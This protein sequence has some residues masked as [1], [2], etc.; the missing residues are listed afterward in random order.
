[1]NF[2]QRFLDNDSKFGQLMTRAGIIIAANLTFLAFCLPVVTIGP[3]WAALH[4]TMLKTLREK[5]L[6]PFSTFWQGFREN[7]FQGLAAELG[8]GMLTVFLL[9]ESFWCSQFT[10]PVAWFRYGVWMLLGC[11]AILGLYLFPVMAAF[12]GSLLQKLQASLVFAMGNIASLAGILLV[13]AAPLALT[14]LDAVRMPLYAFLW[15]MFGFAAVALFTDS[16]LLPAFEP[17]LK[18]LQEGPAPQDQ[19]QEK[20]LQD[21][22]KLGM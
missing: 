20:T 9:L 1:M 14:Y 15:F 13:S 17:Y 11:T 3:A 10:G 8:L 22:L 18:P 6:N 5:E 4:Y 2:L 21:M 12:R 19:S 16:R 7:L